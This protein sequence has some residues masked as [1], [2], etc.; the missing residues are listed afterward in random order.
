MSLSVAPKS[1]LVVATRRFT[2]T[3]ITACTLLVLSACE[4]NNPSPPAPGALQNQP[5]SWDSGAWN[6]ANWT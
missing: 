6:N 5:L 1:P 4:N 3:L 2:F